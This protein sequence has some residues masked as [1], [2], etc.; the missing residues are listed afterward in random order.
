[1]HIL[2]VTNY[3][4]PEIGGSAH[5]CYELARSMTARGHEVTVLTG[6][7]RYNVTDLPPQYRRGLWLTETLEGICVRRIRIPSLPRDNRLA[8]GLEHFLIGLWLS[9]LTSLAG[10]AD[11]AMVDSPPL[12]LAWMVSL[13][14][15]LRRLPVLVYLEDLFPHDAVQL[16]VLNNPLL[17]RLFEGME[18]QTYHLATAAAV[19]SPGNKEYVVQHGGQPKRVHVVY[20]WVDT[21]RIRPGERDNEFAS[22]HGLVGRFVV[23]YAGTMGWAQD[24]QT[25]IA[26]ASRLRDHPKIRFLLVGDGV[27]REQVMARSI[28]LGL[29][30]ILWL[31]MQPWSVYPEVLAASDVSMINLHPNLHTPVVPSKL[32]SIMAAARPV[33]ASLPEI[34]D[35]R[36]VV[37]EAECGI[38][39]DAGDDE[40][41]ASAIL[42]LYSDR[43]LAHD[44]GRRGRVY[45]EANFSRQAC[46]SQMETIFESVAGGNL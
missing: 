45:A 8:R 6:F 37:A 28:E 33:V 24:M 16:G 42:T 32:F 25:I 43:A 21:D 41:L 13:A 15:R 23:S 26:G 19:H 2:I 36:H 3:Y 34:S 5:L 30:N 46:T 31:P 1:M 17:I 18:R 12:P 38:C 27:E 7:P 29:D 20:L 35:A 44:M 10:R 4:P 11:V 14:G 39:V 22:Q 40:A 9:G